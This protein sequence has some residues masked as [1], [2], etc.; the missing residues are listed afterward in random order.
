MPS[1]ARVHPL[2]YLARSTRLPFSVRTVS[3]ESTYAWDSPLTGPIS[4][5]VRTTRH[6]ERSRPAP[7][8]S[9]KNAVRYVPDC[10]PGSAGYAAAALPPVPHTWNS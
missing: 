2:Q 10:S 3:V 6:L 7:V 8:K 5:P 1:P 9:S 4:W